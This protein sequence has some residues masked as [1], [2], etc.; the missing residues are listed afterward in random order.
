MNNSKSTKNLQSIKELDIC[1]NHFIMKEMISLTI[2]WLFLAAC[3]NNNE[4]H[5]RA[6]IDDIK[7]KENTALKEHNTNI[8]VEKIKF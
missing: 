6:V 1:L 7:K 5:V 3:T 8:K 4:D 2:C